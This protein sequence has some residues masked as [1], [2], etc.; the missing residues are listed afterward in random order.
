M[1]R[2]SNSLQILNLNKD[3]ATSQI[4]LVPFPR[5]HHGSEHKN[6]DFDF[7]PMLWRDPIKA[8]T[9]KPLSNATIDPL[10]TLF[11]YTF[12]RKAGIGGKIKADDNHNNLLIQ[13]E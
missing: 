12:S 7:D 10:L 5:N 6:P 9:S 8:H 11:Q 13:L 4:T 1:N 3:T 2:L